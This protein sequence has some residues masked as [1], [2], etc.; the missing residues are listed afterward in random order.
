MF[1]LSTIS[2]KDPCYK[3][4]VRKVITSSCS[5]FNSA[6]SGQL[7]SPYASALE[8]FKTTWNTS[9]NAE[10]NGLQSDIS[11]F[12]AIDFWPRHLVKIL[13]KAK[14]FICEKNTVFGLFRFNIESIEKCLIYSFVEQVKLYRLVYKPIWIVNQFNGKNSQRIISQY[15]IP[16]RGIF[17]GASSIFT[18]VDQY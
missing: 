1:F 13:K 9:F 3:T 16:F 8:H 17:K 15:L 2:I 10:L 18:P 14:Y 11:I 4:I 6:L 7:L 12:L 5:P